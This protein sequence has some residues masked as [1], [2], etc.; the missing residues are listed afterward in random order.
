LL[1]PPTE[2]P[3]E[4][5]PAVLLEVAPGDIAGLLQQFFG[6]PRLGVSRHLAGQQLVVGVGLFVNGGHESDAGEYQRR[7]FLTEVSTDPLVD[8]VAEG[9]DVGLALVRRAAVS[10]IHGRAR[11][12]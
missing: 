9:E 12:G 1:R 8:S 4:A 7:L 3:P 5:F 10:V 2:P 6:R 11:I